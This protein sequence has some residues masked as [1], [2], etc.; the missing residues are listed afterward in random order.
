MER[1]LREGCWQQTCSCGPPSAIEQVER[2]HNENRLLFGG[3]RGEELL[4]WTRPSE[5]DISYT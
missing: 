2:R 3:R 4:S 5:G 1:S